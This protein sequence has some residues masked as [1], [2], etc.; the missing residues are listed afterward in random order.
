MDSSEKFEF[1]TQENLSPEE[2]GKYKLMSSDERK[3]FCK[4][5]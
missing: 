1:Y 3:K 2:Y 4:E 5:R